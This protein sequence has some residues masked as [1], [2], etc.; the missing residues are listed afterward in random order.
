MEFCVSGLRPITV[1]ESL[2]LQWERRLVYHEGQ[3]YDGGPS[4]IE[5]AV[6]YSRGTKNRGLTMTRIQRHALSLMAQRHA[7]SVWT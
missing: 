3:W 2:K 6:P 7:G 4:G 1:E 5:N